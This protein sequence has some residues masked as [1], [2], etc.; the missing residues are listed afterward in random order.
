MS[1]CQ[2]HC[3]RIQD[4][5][6]AHIITQKHKRI[7]NLNCREVLCALSADKCQVSFSFDWRSGH[8]ALPFFANFCQET[9]ILWRLGNGFA[10]SS[11][12][13]SVSRSNLVFAVCQFREIGCRTFW[14]FTMTNFFVLISDQTGPHC[15]ASYI[16]CRW[17]QTWIGFGLGIPQECPYVSLDV[18]WKYVPMKLRWSARDITFVHECRRVPCFRKCCRPCLIRKGVV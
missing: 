12:S 10:L 3:L 1:S 9:C 14:N 18:A 8:K 15:L 4:W 7:L 6:N 5:T 17:T 13:Q 11:V 2:I 16:Q